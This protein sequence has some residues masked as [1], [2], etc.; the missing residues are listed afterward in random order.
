MPLTKIK[1]DIIQNNAITASKL[2]VGKYIKQMKHVRMD[3]Q[4]TTTTTGN[5]IALSLNFDNPVTVGN[6]ILVMSS[7]VIVA[8]DAG[9]NW[10][11]GCD[12]FLGETCLTS[13][14]SV[15]SG[16]Y[17][18]QGAIDNNSDGG[19]GTNFGLKAIGI[20]SSTNPL[21][22]LRVNRQNNWNWVGLGYTSDS[23]GK[24]STNLVAIE[25][26]T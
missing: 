22:S 16:N 14:Q 8:G 24:S 4:M 11:A 25:F 17:I 23:Y 10:G 18:Y 6:Q 5:V 9:T 3:S 26:G 13:S 12:L 15:I 21:V 2:A 19:W 1:T 20:A 7:G